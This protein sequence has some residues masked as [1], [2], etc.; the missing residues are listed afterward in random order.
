MFFIAVLLGPTG[1]RNLMKM[2]LALRSQWPELRGRELTGG[3]ETVSLS[4]PERAC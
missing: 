1:P 4:D 2:C 3:V